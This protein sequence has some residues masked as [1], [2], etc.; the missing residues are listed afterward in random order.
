MKHYELRVV[1]DVPDGLR[2]ED[3]HRDCI[4]ALVDVAYVSNDRGFTNTHVPEIIITLE[5]VDE[6][7]LEFTELDWNFDEDQDEE[8]GQNATMRC[9]ACLTQDIHEVDRALRWNDLTLDDNGSADSNDWTLE[10]GV[11]GDFDFENDGWQCANL[12]DISIP[13]WLWGTVTYP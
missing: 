13:G 4:D 10:A 2:P 8:I 1:V 5:P 3:V 9:P 7:A 6:S 12:H 11:D